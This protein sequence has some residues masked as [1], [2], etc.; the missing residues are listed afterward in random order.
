[1]DFEETM[2]NGA[3]EAE[4][5]LPEEF[6][7]DT[8]EPEEDLATVLNEEGEP[9]PTAEAEEGQQDSEARKEPGYVQGRISKAVSK[10]RAEMEAAFKSQ[11][12][13][14]EAKYAPIQ[15]RIMEMDAQELVRSGKVKDLETAKELVR[16]RQGNPAQPGT[17]SQGD[18]QPRQPNGQFASK[19]EQRDPATAARIDML[20]HQADRIKASGGPDVTN[21][22]MNNEEV[23]RK[24]ISGE[25]DFYDVAE[26]MK[27]PR[28]RPPS[29]T[30]SPNG[31]H[32][33]GTNSIS[34]MSDAQFKKLDKMLDEGVRFTVKR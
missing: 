21:E 24:V 30:R 19:S 25:M 2:V 29:P 1:M 13:A 6:V 34:G 9:D 32:G 8:G 11:L 3:Q 22:F 4:D 31:A 14:L 10:A 12:E 5:S 15:E 28:K 16:Y 20:R 33:V 17:E 26:Q 27:K 7:E 18:S 23:K